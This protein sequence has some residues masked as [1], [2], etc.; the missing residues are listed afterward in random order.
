M[1]EKKKLMFEVMYERDGVGIDICS[2]EEDINKEDDLDDEEFWE[3][4]D[5]EDDLNWE[6]VCGGWV[7]IGNCS[8][9]LREYI[10]INYSSKWIG[11]KLEVKYGNEYKDYFCEWLMEYKDIDIDWDEDDEKKFI[12]IF[13]DGDVEKMKN[14]KKKEKRLC[15]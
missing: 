1:E 2:D 15:Y 6:E 12:K 11:D 4:E 8:S 14:W 13:F 7:K 5:E 3:S 10:E 9:L